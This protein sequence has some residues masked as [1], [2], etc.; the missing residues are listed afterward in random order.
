MKRKFFSIAALAL[1]TIAV[2][3]AQ[4]AKYVFYFIGDGM[5]INHVNGAEMYNAAVE[6]R[7]GIVPLCFSQFP[8]TG[9]S[10]TYSASSRITDSAAAGT[11]M[12]TGTKTNNGALGVD[13]DENPVYSVAVQAKKAGKKVGI[14]T[15]VSIDHATPGAFYAHQKIRSMYYEIATDLPKAGFDFYAGSGFLKPTP[16]GKPS[17]F[18]IFDEAGY[19]VAKGYDDYKAK[20]GADKMILIQKDGKKTNALPYAIDRKEDDLTLT[21]ITKAAIENLSHDNK[22][23]FFLMVEGGKIDWA[24]HA[25]DGATMIKE[26]L[27]FDSAVAEAYAFYKKH[28]KETLII[29]TADHETGGLGLATNGSPLTFKALQYQK[30]SLDKLSDAISNF[31]K[32][33]SNNVS[34]DDMEDFLGEQLGLWE[35]TTPTWDQEKFIRNE[36]NASFVENKVYFE[37]N[38][39]SKSEPLASHAKMVLNHMA[40]LGWTSGGHSAAYVP[41]Y[42]IGAGADLFKG[43]MDN[44]EI[45]KRIAKAAKY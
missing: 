8:V 19:T 24:S 18:S 22:K 11:A 1:M 40:G 4:K 6:G 20:A 37:K 33:K 29:V 35:E 7:I 9:L 28:P 32:E 43:R 3:S 30:C 15:S 17:V 12:A 45:P 36:F 25:N 31:R 44:T 27:D 21:Q 16:E 42:A 41:V 13:T 10:A 39:Y 34:W 14:T 5:G 2:V 38:L 23:G 26:V